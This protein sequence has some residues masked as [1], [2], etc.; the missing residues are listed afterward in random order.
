M[1]TNDDVNM[2]EDRM[3]ELDGGENS[4]GELPW[5]GQGALDD[6]PIAR[7]I[8]TAKPI[9]PQVQPA[10]ALRLESISVGAAWLDL[11]VMVLALV[12]FD[13]LASALI[14]TQQGAVAP[15]SDEQAAQRLQAVLPYV[16][17]GR[18]LVVVFVI[19]VVSRLRGLGCR[20][21]GCTVPHFG[22]NCFVGVAALGVAWSLIAVCQLLLVALV[23]GYLEETTKNVEKISEILPK[24]PML[25]FLMLS[26]FVGTY[27]E[28]LFRGFLLPRLRRATGSW[29]AA[30]V[31]ST[32]VFVALHLSTQTKAII[33]PL[34]ILS[35]TFCLTTIWRR[36]LVPA[37][38]GHALFDLI[39]F[40]IISHYS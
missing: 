32:A 17:G 16:I 37:I 25:G 10:L 26:L 33:V 22:K 31:I 15:L 18:A 23:P 14:L 27:E 28:L 4:F 34:S 12:L 7:P 1:T 40:L 5:G 3:D 8:W 19:A 35:I 2:S 11:F 9:K 39:Q 38:V 6:I 21:V 36:S 13:F 24:L 30:V 20:S 29:I